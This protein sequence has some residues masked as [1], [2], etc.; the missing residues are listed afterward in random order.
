MSTDH[1]ISYGWYL[2]SEDGKKDVEVVHLTVELINIISVN[3]VLVEGSYNETFCRCQ[4]RG[5]RA[6]SFQR[7]EYTYVKAREN[8]SFSEISGGPWWRENIS[9]CSS[10][11]VR[12]VE[13]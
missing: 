1:D 8:V 7:V 10:S 4:Y 11:V 2:K 5:L 12:C 9:P 13:V 3:M 6:I